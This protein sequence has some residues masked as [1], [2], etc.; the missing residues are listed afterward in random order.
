MIHDTSQKLQGL[1]FPPD[2]DPRLNR[3]G[4]K[5][6]DGTWVA[7][8][9]VNRKGELLVA[10]DFDKPWRATR[11]ENAAGTRTRGLF[12][13]VEH[14]Q[15]RLEDPNGPAGNDYDA[16]RPGLTAAQYDRSVLLYITASVRAGRWL[17]PAFHGVID[18]GVGTHDDPQNFARGDWE[19]A[20]ERRLRDLGA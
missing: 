1:Q 11:L 15:P 18:K 6:S 13:H 17:I 9:F 8:V 16:P 3:L 19:A 12:L 5:H 7:H 20:L 10:Y 14:N 2:D 4:A